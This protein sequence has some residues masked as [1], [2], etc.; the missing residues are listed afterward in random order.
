MV[1]ICIIA[2]LFRPLVAGS[3][4]FGIDALC[5]VHNTVG[6][7]SRLWSTALGAGA[8]ASC[9]GTVLSLV[10]VVLVECMIQIVQSYYLVSSIDEISIVGNVVIISLVFLAA[11]LGL[12]LN[13]MMRQQRLREREYAQ[14]LD[15]QNEQHKVEL[16]DYALH[17]HDHVLGL[18]VNVAL[19]ANRHMGSKPSDD[20][21]RE[22]ASGPRDESGDWTLV[23]E[24]TSEA[25]RDIHHIVRHMSSL[26]VDDHKVAA[27][28]NVIA[29]VRSK[30]RNVDNRLSEQGFHGRFS[31]N[32]GGFECIPMDKR[33][34][35]LDNVMHA[36]AD[37]I[38]ATGERDG[39]YEVSVMLHGT[40]AEIT[41]T[42]PMKHVD[43]KG[44]MKAGGASDEAEA[45]AAVRS[46]LARIGGEL[47]VCVD[48]EDCRSTY[49][50]VPL[51][52]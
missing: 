27:I 28:T 13:G 16:L 29:L 1:L 9:I 47:R 45:Y 51:I 12:F 21:D 5:A 40:T 4:L 18:L 11:L 48:D 17:M 32:D 26:N 37:D 42:H 24:Q 19:A 39:A 10:I 30:A 44:R 46:R 2:A 49:V 25:I 52:A 33:L 6:G 23:Y 43:E 8:I 35:L 36:V 7:P 31:V 50:Y 34:S 3:L 14:N 38:I 41:E 20:G 22:S 15:R